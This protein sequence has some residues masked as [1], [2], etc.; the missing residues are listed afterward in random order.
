VAAA[1]VAGSL[2]VL[3]SQFVDAIVQLDQPI[4]SSIISPGEATQL[5]LQLHLSLTGWFTFDLLVAFALFAATM[6]LGHLRL[7]HTPAESEASPAGTCPGGPDPRQP[8]S[9]P[10]S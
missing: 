1:V 3:A 2:I 10:G 6:V 4:P 5:G 8:A 9:L 7:V